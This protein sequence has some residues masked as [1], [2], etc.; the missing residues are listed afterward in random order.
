MLAIEWICATVIVAAISY[1][2]HEFLWM[3]KRKRLP[4]GPKPLPI[5]GNLHLLG[6]NPHQ[7]LFHLAKKHGPIMYMQWG[8]VPAIIISSPELA[9]KFLKT[10]DLNFASRPYHEGSWYV[11]H[12]QRNLTFAKY[13]PYWRNMRKLCTLELLSNFK[14]N[15]FQSMRKRELGFLIESL[16]RAS[17]DQVV[18]D[19]SGE[20]SSLSA[21]MSCLMIFGK[22]YMDKDFDDRGFKDVIQ[23]LLHIAAIP[24]LGDFFPFLGVLDLQ[25]LTRRYKALGKVFDD[26]LERIID[27]HVHQSSNIPKQ[28]RDFVDTMMSILQSGEADFEFDRRHIKSVLIDVLIA[29]MDT[30]ATA[31]EWVFTE[32]LRHPHYMKKLQEEIDEKVGM[33]STVEESNLDGLEYLDMVIK[34]TFRLH[35]VA[36]LLLPHESIDD[37]IIDG[38]H[39]PKKS[40]ILINTMAIGRD[41]MVWSEPERFFPERFVEDNVDIK[42]KDFRL[43]PFGSGRRMCPGMHLGL[44]VVRLVVAQLVHC[45]DWKLPN[46]MRPN[47]LDTN[48][49]F[50]LVTSR[51]N[52][53]MAVPMYRLKE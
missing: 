27:E 40:R 3:K 12:E 34:E 4:P 17:S 21:N 29:S 45:F 13:G 43:I 39:I 47:D 32:L 28:N 48:E 25:G 19:L 49:V 6:K 37:C 7:D 15:Q 26:F 33:N 11:A 8:F 5:L 50:G 16:K 30:S 35:P 41:P 20:V 2:L 1:L 38:Y 53:L 52:H 23:E 36:P 31:V 22:K 46:D 44:T 24:N 51:A 14:I 9:E 18:V 42:G 10:H